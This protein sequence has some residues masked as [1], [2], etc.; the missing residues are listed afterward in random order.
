MIATKCS[1]LKEGINDQL[2]TIYCTFKEHQRYELVTLEFVGRLLR[3]C[4][5]LQLQMLMFDWIFEWARLH[6]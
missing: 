6:K 4:L 1:I 5:I 2:I 3:I